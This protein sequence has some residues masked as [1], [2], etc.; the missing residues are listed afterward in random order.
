MAIADYT[1]RRALKAA[2]ASAA[3]LAMASALP[4]R[5]LAAASGA[6]ISGR[7]Q[8]WDWSDAPFVPGEQTQAE[9]YRKHFPSLYKNLQFTSS[10][11]GY[12][13]MLPKLTVA[14]RAS[15][16]PD[17]ARVAVAWSPQFVGSGQCLEIT[18]DELG[19]PFAQFLPSALLSVRRNGAS[20]GPLYGVPT[21]N[22]AMLL[23]YNKSIF[24]RAGLDPNTP[25]AT[26]ADLVAYSKTIHDKT[27][28]YGYGLC[29]AQNNGN[30]PYRFM[31]MAWAYGGQVFD[32]LSPH[33]TW[34]NIGIGDGGV[35]EALSLYKQMFNVDKSVQPS[36]LSDNE[37]ERGDAVP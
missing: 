9:F 4:R 29:G 5:G 37:F 21:N 13:D 18:E 32:E 25:P 35:V 10:I 31:P 20:T 30:T 26:W 34:R 14:W 33:P 28:A 8:A 12:S 36:A 17:V 2:A 7:L 23:I 1:R 27:G 19:M 24:S 3:G 16:R 22:E 6:A 11:F 15:N